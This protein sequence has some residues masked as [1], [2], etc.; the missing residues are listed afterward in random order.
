MG[1]DSKQSDLKALARKLRREAYLDAK[2]KKKALD[3]AA[4]LAEAKRKEE[5]QAAKTEQKDRRLWSLV[6]PASELD[7][8]QGMKG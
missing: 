4:K 2:A 6:R 3:Q 7:K 5:E 8:S 1:T